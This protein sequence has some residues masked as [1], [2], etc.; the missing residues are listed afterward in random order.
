[1]KVLLPTTFATFWR[2]LIEGAQRG[3]EFEVE[4]QGELYHIEKHEG[5][6][7]SLVSQDGTRRVQLARTAGNGLVAC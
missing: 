3:V 4:H 5:D 1:M 7:L 6:S 2:N